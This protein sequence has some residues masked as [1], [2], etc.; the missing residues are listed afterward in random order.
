MRSICSK[1]SFFIKS[2]PSRMITE[3]LAE[4]IVRL[5]LVELITGALIVP[6]VV[7]PAMLDV[8]SKI[9][10]FRACSEIVTIY[11]I[12]LQFPTHSALTLHSVPSPLFFINPA[13][14]VK[15]SDFQYFTCKIHIHQNPIIA[16]PK[17]INISTFIMFQIVERVIFYSFYLFYY[18]F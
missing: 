12:S 4:L 18:S 15:Y 16:Y 1:N 3:P 10:D 14:V 11:C 9:K 8:M 2:H 7:I 17:L 5:F 13:S 6:F